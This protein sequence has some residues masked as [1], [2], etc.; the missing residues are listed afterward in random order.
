MWKSNSH[1]CV[2]N[3]SSFNIFLNSTNLAKTLIS[4]HLLHRRHQHYDLFCFAI[5]PKLLTN[6]VT[7][8]MRSIASC[9]NFQY[10]L[11]SLRSSSSCLRL[12]R[13]LTHPIFSSIKSFRRQLLCKMRP[14]KL[15]FF[16]VLLYVGCL[17]PPSFFVILHF[18]LD[19]SK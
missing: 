15:T 19:P 12:L 8:R 11:F 13:L 18:S 7:Y 1:H 9:F 5:G 16:F 10:L 4:K 2:H 17:N 3:S 14:V 6:K